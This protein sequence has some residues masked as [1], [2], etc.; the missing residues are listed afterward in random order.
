MVTTVTLVTLKKQQR[1]SRYIVMPLEVEH[2]WT[3]QNTKRSP[4][5]Y[6]RPGGI[7]TLEWSLVSLVQVCKAR[8]Q[9]TSRIFDL[10]S[11]DLIRLEH[12]DGEGLPFDYHKHHK[13]LFPLVHVRS[14]G[15][16]IA[17]SEDDNVNSVAPRTSSEAGGTKADQE[18]L[19][20]HHPKKTCKP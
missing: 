15:S 19:Q 10:W 9:T 13:F 17:Y 14:V 8:W 5:V 3:S 11:I 18:E 6:L 2:I 1:P 20:G 16:Q 4:E 7:K 12:V